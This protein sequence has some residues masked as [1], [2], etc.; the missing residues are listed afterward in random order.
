MQ[1]AGR[2][3]PGDLDFV[4]RAIATVGNTATSRG[5]VTGV[6]AG[7]VTVTA[8]IQAISGT[9]QVAVVTKL[10]TSVQITPTQ[11]ILQKGVTQP[12]LATATYDDNTTG[13]VTQQATWSTGDASVLTVVAS[14][15]TA[16]LV[17]AQA[18]GTTSIKA[19]LGTISGYDF[20][21]GHRAD[22]DHHHNQPGYRHH[23]RGRHQLVHGTGK[24]CRRQHRRPD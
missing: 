20:R 18:A 15:A 22:A 3:G 17:T 5:Q 11:P 7:T 12:F 16:G 19:T 23:R 10:V 13:D 14:G 4:E 1:Q 9:V 2:D 21:D 24:L 6:S 8:T